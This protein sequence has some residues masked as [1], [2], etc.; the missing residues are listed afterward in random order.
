MTEAPLTRVSSP[1]SVRTSSPPRYTFTNGAS[2][3]AVEEL[4]LERRVPAGEVLEHLAHRLALAD[5]LALA[6]D[7]VPQ[8]RR[9][10]DSRHGRTPAQNS[11]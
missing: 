7:L 8:R 4:R 6:A 11:T 2:D 10:P 3:T 5:E 9:N 1:S